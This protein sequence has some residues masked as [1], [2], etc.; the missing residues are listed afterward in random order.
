[1]L[2]LSERPTLSGETLSILLGV[3]LSAPAVRIAKLP[4]GDRPRDEE[5]DLFGMTHV[6]NVRPENEDHFLL[7]TL[8]RSINVHATSLPAPE[9]LPLKSERLATVAMVADGVGGAVAGSQASELAVERVAGYVARALEILTSD[10]PALT[11]E[12]RAA[13]ETAALAAHEA[14]LGRAATDPALRG[15]AT[16][17]TLMIS[18]WPNA[19]IVQVGDS[20]CYY[21]H[22]G[23]LQRM[24]RDQ[25]LAQELV[26]AG[27]LRADEAQ[28][29]PLA[30]VLASALGGGEARPVVATLTVQRGCAMVLCTD[31]LTKHV[32]DEEIAAHLRTATS[33]EQACRALVDLALERGGSDNVTVVIGRAPA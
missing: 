31:G 18:T 22:D 28:Q 17:L 24:T 23:M 21:W 9:R 8:H 3:L 32:S 7:C 30:N 25:T 15:M 1:M 2:P 19:Y 33:S 4:R 11:G 6:G 27:A 13:L 16:T 5:I 10:D 14:V 29:S 20:R 26:D 12:F